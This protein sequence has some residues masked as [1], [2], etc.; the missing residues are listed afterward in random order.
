MQNFGLK[1]V[2]KGFLKGLRLDVI[3]RNVLKGYLIEE[4]GS[5][6]FLVA[7]PILEEVYWMMILIDFLLHTVYLLCLGCI[8]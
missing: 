4:V 2:R 5:Y 6:L 7:N 3:T 8:H 1:E